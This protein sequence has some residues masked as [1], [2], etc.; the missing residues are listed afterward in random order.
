MRLFK[1]KASTLPPVDDAL[2]A[3]KA[4]QSRLKELANNV[5]EVHTPKLTQNDIDIFE[6]LA[7]INGSTIE[8]EELIKQL[9]ELQAICDTRIS[10]LT[11]SLEVLINHLNL[12]K[13]DL[14]DDI[15]NLNLSF[16]DRAKLL[17]LNDRIDAT[18]DANL[19]INDMIDKTNGGN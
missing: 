3:M 18:E 1:H 6:K 17:V 13:D 16:R 8:L 11:D 2:T 15:S 10:T 12:S 19:L 7:D 14:L 5:Q 4:S 9:N